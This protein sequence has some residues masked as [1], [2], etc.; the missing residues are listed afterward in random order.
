MATAFVPILGLLLLSQLGW[1]RSIFSRLL[2]YLFPPATDE[3]TV[4]ADPVGD[5]RSAAS[6]LR[7]SQL[8]NVGEGVFHLT[9]LT[10]A[11]MREYEPDFG[12]T[13]T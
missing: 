9:L 6:M 11:L 8:V 4:E 12:F 13:T 5:W 3:I 1:I 7:L 2:A 10:E